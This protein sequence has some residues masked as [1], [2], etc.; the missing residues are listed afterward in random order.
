MLLVALGVYATALSWLQSGRRPAITY[1]GAQLAAAAF[2]IAGLGAAGPTAV[3]RHSGIGA[4]RATAT[5]ESS[6]Q[7]RDWVH[8]QQR[9]IV[10]DEDGTESSVALAAEPNGYAFIVNGKSDGSARG[11]AG[12]QVMLGLLGA[13]LNPE[14]RRS[15]VIG[16]GTGSSAGWLAAVPGMDRV[17]V[18]ELEPLIVDVARACDAVNREV[19]RNLKVHLT[20]GDARET[21]LTGREGYDLIAS[22][23]SNPFRAGV[24]SLFTRDYYAAARERLTDDGLFLQWVQLYEIDARTLG[25]VYATIASVFPNVEAW[26]AGGG[27]LVLVAAKKRLT[28]RADIARRAHSAGAVQDGAQR[29]LAGRRSC[30][31]AGALPGERTIWRARW[32]TPPASKSTPTTATSSSSVSPGRWAAAPRCSP[33]CGSWR[34]RRAIHARRFPT[35][36]QSIGPRWTRRGSGIRRPS[37]TSR[38]LRCPVRPTSRRGSRR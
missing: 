35:S 21:L 37:S 33:S 13:I 31:P 6:N 29:R 36:L 14:A 23:P 28:Y 34:G 8:A 12:T 10:W 5:L 2:A 22:E 19:L 26:E 32:Q 15:L 24:A 25:T 3:W 7:F 38:G 30:R 11:D 4:G 20:I 27:D 17:D 18:V 1:L 16:L 9:A